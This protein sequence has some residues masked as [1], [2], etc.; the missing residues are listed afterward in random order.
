MKT[1]FFLA[2]GLTILCAMVSPLVLAEG[3]RID[4]SSRKAIYLSGNKSVIDLKN[5]KYVAAGS[6]IK[7]KRSDAVSCSGNKCTYGLGAIAFRN[8]TTNSLQTYGQ[9]TGKTLGIVGN[10]IIFQ[11]NETTKQ[12]VLPVDLTVG[13]N[14][15]T[16]TIDPQNKIAETNETNNSFTVT[17]IVE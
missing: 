14:A 2:F 9:F 10:T 5:D 1:K 11:N 3:E 7:V 12:Q 13:T 4:L 16:F 15:V 8:G 6:T 17:I